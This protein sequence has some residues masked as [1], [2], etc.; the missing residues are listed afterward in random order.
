MLRTLQKLLLLTA[1][2]VTQ[3]TALADACL[4]AWKKSAAASSCGNVSSSDETHTAHDTGNNTCEISVVCK[5]NTR[6][7]VFHDLDSLRADEVSRLVNTDGRLHLSPLPPT[8]CADAWKKSSARNSCSIYQYDDRTSNSDG[9]VKNFDDARCKVNMWCKTGQSDTAPKKHNTKDW[10]VG[11]VLK[12][13]NYNG[14]LKI[15]P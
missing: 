10:K 13:G 1:I 8:A 2:L 14:D 3:Q 12:L 11:E 4:D 15:S 7:P 5:S 6:G 9:E